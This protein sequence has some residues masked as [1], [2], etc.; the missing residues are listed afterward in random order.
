[1][2]EELTR[3]L[4]I[5]DVKSISVDIDL[6]YFTLNVPYVLYIN[7]KNTTSTMTILKISMFHPFLFRCD[8]ESILFFQFASSSS[9]PEE[10]RFFFRRN[11]SSRES[12]TQER[13]NFFR[14]PH[15]FS[16]WILRDR[17]NL[18]KVEGF[19]E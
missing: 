15:G 16:P 2:T 6:S 18:K 12:V 13:G 1:M 3:K 10:L 7:L 9:D 14:F 5:F 19:L 4:K 11:T 17:G 8:S